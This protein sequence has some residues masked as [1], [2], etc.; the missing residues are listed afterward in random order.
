MVGSGIKIYLKEKPI[1][2]KMFPQINV[3]YQTLEKQGKLYT[4]KGIQ[5]L[6]TP[7]VSDSIFRTPF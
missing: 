2:P 6:C 7:P 1:I 5:I 4:H 3:Q